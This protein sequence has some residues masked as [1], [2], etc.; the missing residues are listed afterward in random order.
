MT[1]GEQAHVLIPP[2]KA[3][4]IS[5]LDA[6]ARNMAAAKA[7]KAS[8]MGPFTMDWNTSRDAAR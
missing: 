2:E 3:S 6:L 4:T 5:L 8:P 1:T 7:K